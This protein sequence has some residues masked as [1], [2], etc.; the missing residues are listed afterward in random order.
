M[1]F[2][3]NYM[4]LISGGMIANSNYEMDKTNHQCWLNKG[5]QYN[6]SICSKLHESKFEDFITQERTYRYNFMCS[7][8]SHDKLQ[9][10]YKDYI[11]LFLPV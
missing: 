10:Y 2:K 8:A 7:L 6:T 3:K 9:L 5:P 11:G 4:K 1:K